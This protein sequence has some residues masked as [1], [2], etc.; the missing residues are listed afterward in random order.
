MEKTLN[1]KAIFDKYFQ[2]IKVLRN[3]K[4]EMPEQEDLNWNVVL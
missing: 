1:Y 4:A 3:P 2:K